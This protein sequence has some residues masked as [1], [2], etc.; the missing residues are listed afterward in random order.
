MQIH[1]LGRDLQSKFRIKFVLITGYVFGICVQFIG[2]TIIYIYIYIY[3]Y[4]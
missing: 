1:F 3:V 2:N 4:M